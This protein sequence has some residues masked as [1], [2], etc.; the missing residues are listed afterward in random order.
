[1]NVRQTITEH[2]NDALENCGIEPLLNFDDEM[3]L[4]N[5]GLDSLGFA[6]LIAK[7][8]QSLGYDPFTLMDE[9]F[10]P[11]TF[12]EFVAIYEKYGD[13]AAGEL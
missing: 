5:S 9:P 3:V 12:R 8:E 10:Y 6:I 4:L 13:R 7:L 11:R 2:Y 1:M